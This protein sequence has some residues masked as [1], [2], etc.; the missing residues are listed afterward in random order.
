VCCCYYYYSFLNIILLL[1][2]LLSLSSSSTFRKNALLTQAPGIL[3][4]VRIVW[5]ELK[6][7]TV[8]TFLSVSVINDISNQ[9]LQKCLWL[10]SIQNFEKR[11]SRRLLVF[12]ITLQA[13]YRFHA[14]A[15]LTNYR[16]TTAST[17]DAYFRRVIIIHN[18]RTRD[19]SIDPNPQIVD[20][21][22]RYYSQTVSDKG[23]WPT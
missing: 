20:L 23:Q 2:L 18:F 12:V 19:V 6:Y 10:I 16:P 15:N 17:E 21:P 5:N 9:N 7:D 4:Y 8:T 11:E 3:I 1:L 14:V 13:G 22:R